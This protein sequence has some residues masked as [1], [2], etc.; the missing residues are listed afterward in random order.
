M[1]PYSPEPLD[2]AR[3][4]E[5]AENF[6]IHENA[7][8]AKGI[9]LENNIPQDLKV[10]A[11]RNALQA[12]LRNL[13]GNAV[14]F[15]P[16]GGRVS[17]GCVEKDGHVFITVND[18]GTGIAAEK[19][20]QLFTLGKRNNT[21]PATKGAGLGLLLCK[22]LVEMN[23]GTLRVFSTQGEGSTFEFCLPSA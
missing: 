19:M 16:T 12:I 7:A 20:E 18:T 13:L 9:L 8:T 5:S 1:I 2:L 14:K 23:Q 10:Q 15:T 3:E 21:A 4:R 11:D 22:E 6:E 17:L